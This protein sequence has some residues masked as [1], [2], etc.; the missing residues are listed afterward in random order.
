MRFL[1]NP[2][3]PGF[4]PDP[5]VCRVGEE[6]YLVTSTFEYFPG[7]PVFH[8]RDLVHWEQIGHCLT[9]PSQL[10]LEG[11]PPSKGIYAPTLR[12]HEGCFYMITT[13]VRGTGYWENVNFFVTA[14]NPAGPWSEPVV[15]EGADGIDPTLFFEGGKAYYLGNMRPDPNAGSARYIWLQELELATG[16][17]LG[18]RTI[19]RTDGAV[20]NAHAPEA[21]HLYHVGEYYYLMIAEG[22]TTMNHAVSLFRSRTLFGPYEVNPRNP[23]F[24]HRHF[25][26]NSPINSTG[27]ADLVETQNGEWWAVMLASRPDGGAFRCLGRE[28]YALPVIWEDG[29][30]VF[31][32]DTGRMEL[33]FPAPALPECRWP[34]VLACEQF[35]S[36]ALPLHF[37]LLRTPDA[38]RPPYSLESRPG[39]LRLF[40][41]P[42][43][44]AEYRCPA[45]VGRR[46]QHLS[47]CVAAR[48]A[49][50]PARE[51]EWAGL[52]IL[53]SAGYQLRMELGL[54]EGQR[55]LRL[56][57]RLDGCE[58]VTAQLPCQ[59]EELVLRMESA[60][61]DCTFSFAVLEEGRQQPW[62]LLAEHV[63]LL[64]YSDIK[65]NQFTGTF[66]GMYATAN[67]APSD[68]Y[69]DFDWFQ[70]QALP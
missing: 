21:P 37:S 58:T 45:F 12:Y 60:L 7:V 43:T 5:S 63:S 9:R 2:L 39:C 24:T 28:T 41:L 29:W 13:L 16:R 27:H 64:P 62:T 11:V 10:D 48:M 69:A 23:V 50:S 1:C 49:F 46:Q 25:G 30:P 31:S 32:P 36:P 54:R 66:L 44:L 65:A 40:C 56:V 57:Q 20:Y 14:E 4:Y 22:G 38:A 61:Q 18:E 17:L 26:R 15:V 6:Y 35:D 59:A 53:M 67:G 33:A 68:N 3:L 8:S 42:Q 55:V 19:L 51:G 70:Y 52:V 34:A 47:F